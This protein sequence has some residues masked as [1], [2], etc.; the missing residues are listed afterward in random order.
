VVVD[1]DLC[2]IELNVG[3]FLVHCRID[4]AQECRWVVFTGQEMHVI[5][6]FSAIF[7]DIIAVI[8]FILPPL[9]VHY[10]LKSTKHD[11]YNIMNDN[12]EQKKNT[13]HCTISS[14]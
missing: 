11:I 4:E 5:L 12:Y 14:F 3:T 13:C 6:S 7:I 9:G 8:I 2:R 10:I 1:I